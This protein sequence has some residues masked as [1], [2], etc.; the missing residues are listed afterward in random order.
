MQF[1]IKHMNNC[2]IFHSMPL[3]SLKAV[4]LSENDP[5]VRQERPLQTC[6][7]VL[8]FF[9]SLDM[10][11]KQGPTSS[12]RIASTQIMVMKYHFTLKETRFS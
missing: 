9:L 10:P 7:Q 3:V 1:G 8:V 5:D 2:I 12:N 11:R 6:N 4:I